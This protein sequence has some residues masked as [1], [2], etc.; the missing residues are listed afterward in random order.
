MLRFDYLNDILDNVGWPEDQ[1]AFLVDTA[2]K[3]ITSTRSFGRQGLGESGDSLE[4]EVLRNLKEKDFGTVMGE[5]RPPKRVIGFY[6]LAEAPWY[7]ILVSP[8]QKILSP[9]IRFTLYYA[10][11]AAGFI[12]CILLVMRYTTGQTVRSIQ[13]VSTAAKNI[14]KGVF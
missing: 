12:I 2:G 10:L 5:G 3:I 8:G 7:L 13:N 6:L 11:I 4:L 1:A 9:V 14:S